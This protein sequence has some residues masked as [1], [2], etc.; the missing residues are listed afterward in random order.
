MNN[1]HI[2]FRKDTLAAPLH[3]GE[4]NIQGGVSLYIRLFLYR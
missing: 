3:D 2:Q 1:Q 4:T